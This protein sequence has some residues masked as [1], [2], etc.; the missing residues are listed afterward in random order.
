M[1][2]SS[3]P[4]SFDV[5]RAWDQEIRAKLPEDSYWFATLS[6]DTG[7]FDA[8]IREV[9]EHRNSRA[10]KDLQDWLSR[11]GLP[12]HSL[13]KFRHGNAVYS[14][15][16]A[17]DIAD[18]KAVSQNLMHSSL[19]VTDGVYGILST[20]DVGKR[21]AGLGGKLAAGQVDHADIAQQLMEI[22]QM[23]KNNSH[24]SGT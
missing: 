3:K 7:S 2:C 19:S 14:V 18:L 4:G 9:G 1:R 24:V 21:I 11:V 10:L 12:Y 16:H 17:K 5:V 23:L 8:S 20:A 6:P 13:H 22:A 15:Q